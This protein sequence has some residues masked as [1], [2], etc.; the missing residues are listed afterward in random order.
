MIFN[1][2]Q[3]LSFL[4]DKDDSILFEIKEFVWNRT[5]KQN[6]LYWKYLE[7]LTKELAKNNIQTNKDRLHIWLSNYLLA[8]SYRICEI[9]WKRLVERKSTTELSKIEF[10]QYIKD[11]EKFMWEQY[12]TTCPLATDYFYNK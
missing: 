7:D 11:I 9:T 2:Q 3:I 4:K 10:S 1:K 12:Q 8:G 6:A 5:N